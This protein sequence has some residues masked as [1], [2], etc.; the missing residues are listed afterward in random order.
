[1]KRTYIKPETTIIGMEPVVMIA[2]SGSIGVNPD[3]EGTEQLGNRHR[4]TWG[5]LW[6]KDE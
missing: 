3:E 4:G 6:D 2:S 1:M 5:N